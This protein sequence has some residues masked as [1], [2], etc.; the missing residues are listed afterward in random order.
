MEIDNNAFEN[1]SNLCNI[2]LPSATTHISPNAFS[3]CCKLDNIIFENRFIDIDESAFENSVNVVINSTQYS[4]AHIYAKTNRYKFHPT[5]VVSEYCIV[6]E[7]QLDTIAK[8]GIAFFAKRPDPT[9]DEFVI[10]FDKSAE[11]RIIELIG[12]IQND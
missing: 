10:Q 4:S 9:K 7:R 12:G 3:F 5:I 8:A 1:C 6:T 2:T 11:D